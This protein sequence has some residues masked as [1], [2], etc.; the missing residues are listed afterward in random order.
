MRFFYNSDD[1]YS[2]LF[3][4]FY[5]PHF[6]IAFRKFVDARKKNATSSELNFSELLD[7][8]NLQQFKTTLSSTVFPVSLGVVKTLTFSKETQSFPVHRWIDWSINMFGKEGTLFLISGREPSVTPPEL[9]SPGSIGAAC[10]TDATGCSA[11][12]PFSDMTTELIDFFQKA[13]IALHW[14]S[15]T[16]GPT[17]PDPIL[18]SS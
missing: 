17:H 8:K 16:G 7:E 6:S 2:S 14:L 10:N 13:P 11:T 5:I 1:P 4:V 9:T 3:D 18:I 15:G 12:K